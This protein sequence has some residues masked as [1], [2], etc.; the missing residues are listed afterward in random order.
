MYWVPPR[1]GP[2][3]LRAP[4]SCSAANTLPSVE[5]SQPGTNRGRSASA[6]ATS[7]E[8]AGSVW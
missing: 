6:A 5:S 4:R 7:Q 2:G 8:P 3:R 1:T